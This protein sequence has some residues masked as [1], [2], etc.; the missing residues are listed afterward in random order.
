M[1]PFKKIGSFAV[2]LMAILTCFA[3]QKA[4]GQ[5]PNSSEQIDSFEKLY[6]ALSEGAILDLSDP[7]NRELFKLYLVENFVTKNGVMFLDDLISEL[8][9]NMDFKLMH[10]EGMDS[11]LL[12]AQQ[13]LWVRPLSIWEKP[14][15]GV[16]G[17]DCSTGSYP[18]K[19]LDPNFWVYTITNDRN[20]SNGHI[21]VVL[22]TAKGEK[23]KN[24]KIAMVDKIQSIPNEYI[25]DMLEMI[26]QSVALKGYQLGIPA[27]MGGTSD[28]LS[29]SD[30]IATFVS[31]EYDPYVNS[32]TKVKK[33]NAH[34]F[35]IESDKGYSRAYDS[36]DLV[37]LETP[38]N[39]KQFNTKKNA[40]NRA[41]ETSVVLNI[42][43]RISIVPE[44][45]TDRIDRVA[46]FSSYGL[47]S[48]LNMEMMD[49]DQWIKEFPTFPRQTQ[50]QL[51]QLFMSLNQQKA[52]DGKSYGLNTLYE[53]LVEAGDPKHVQDFIVLVQNIVQD[54]D[55]AFIAARYISEDMKKMVDQFIQNDESYKRNLK[56]IL[57]GYAK[58][59]A[60]ADFFSLMHMQYVRNSINR[61]E[62]V[63][64][65]KRATNEW[66]QLI[67]SK[68]G[69]ELIYMTDKGRV[70]I[71]ISAAA[72]RYTDKIA[73][74]HYPYDYV[75]DIHKNKFARIFYSE[76]FRNEIFD[77]KPIKNYL[78]YNFNEKHLDYI[79][80]AI[81]KYPDRIVRYLSKVSSGYDLSRSSLE[82]MRLRKRVPYL[83]LDIRMDSQIPFNEYVLHRWINLSGMDQFVKKILDRYEEGYFLGGGPDQKLQ[84]KM[85]VEEAVFLQKFSKLRS[86]YIIECLD[87]FLTPSEMG[88]G[89]VVVTSEYRKYI[90]VNAEAS[91]HMT[92]DALAIEKFVRDIE[93]NPVQQPVFD[94][95]RKG[96]GFDPKM[97]LHEQLKD[98][99]KLEFYQKS[100]LAHET[101]NPIEG[102]DEPG[103]V[104]EKKQAALRVLWR[105][106]LVNFRG[107]VSSD[108]ELKLI[109]NK[110][111]SAGVKIYGDPEYIRVTTDDYKQPYFQRFY[112]ATDIE[113]RASTAKEI[114]QDHIRINAFVSQ[115]RAQ[116]FGK[117]FFKDARA[118]KDQINSFLR[119]VFGY[120]SS[121]DT[122]DIEKFAES[123]VD[124]L[125][126]SA[127]PRDW[128]KRI[129]AL[130]GLI[131]ALQ[132]I[133]DTKPELKSALQIALA[134]Q[135]K[136]IEA[137]NEKIRRI[138]PLF[139]QEAPYAFNEDRLNSTAQKIAKENAEAG[140]A[141]SFERLEA[142][143]KITA[144]Q[145]RDIYLHH[146]NKLGASVVSAFEL[147][148][149]YE[150]KMFD[151]S[152]IKNFQ[153]L[154]DFYIQFFDDILGVDRAFINQT[155][156]SS[157]DWKLNDAQI[158]IFKSKP[159]MYQEYFSDGM[160]KYDPKQFLKVSSMMDLK[161][162]DT[163]LIHV[164]KRIEKFISE[165]MYM[166]VAEDATALD[167]V[168][169]LSDERD[170][171][172]VLK[173]YF[174]HP[175]VIQ[176][177]VILKK[178]MA[179][180]KAKKVPTVAE[181]TE[182]VTLGEYKKPARALIILEAVQNT[183][184]SLKKDLMISLL[185]I[186]SEYPLLK[187]KTI[188]EYFLKFHEAKVSITDKELKGIASI[189]A[190]SYF[191]DLEEHQKRAVRESIALIQERHP[192]IEK[193]TLDQV[194][195]SWF[196]AHL[197]GKTEEKGKELVAD[198]VKRKALVKS[199]DELTKLGI[200][201]DVSAEVTRKLA[202]STV[203]VL[204]IRGE[205][206]FKWTYELI[207]Q[208]MDALPEGKKIKTTHD[209]ITM[210]KDARK[211]AGLPDYYT[212][213]DVCE[214]EGKQLEDFGIEVNRME[215]RR[216]FSERFK[217]TYN[218]IANYVSG[219]QDVD[220]SRAMNAAKAQAEHDMATENEQVKGIPKPEAIVT[221]EAPPKVEDL[222]L[223][224]FAKEVGRWNK[225]NPTQIIDSKETYSYF[226]KQAISQ[227]IKLQEFD[228]L[229]VVCKKNGITPVRFF[230]LERIYRDQLLPKAKFETLVSWAKDEISLVEK[231]YTS[232]IAKSYM[233]NS[234]WMYLWFKERFQARQANQGNLSEVIEH[235]DMIRVYEK[236][237]ELKS[238]EKDNLMISRAA[239]IPTT[240][241]ESIRIQEE[242]SRRA[243]ET[244]AVTPENYQ[245]LFVNA[246]SWRNWKQ[247]E[248]VLDYVKINKIQ[249]SP[250][251][252][253]SPMGYVILTG[254]A[255]LTKQILEYAQKSGIILSKY[256]IEKFI[257]LA[258]DSYHANRN[259]NEVVIQ[260]LDL[261]FEY[262]Q[263][264]GI[265]IGQ[266]I[267]NE[268]VVMCGRN[269][270]WKMAEYMMGKGGEIEIGKNDRLKQTQ[271][272]RLN[273]IKAS[274][275]AEKVAAASL[276]PSTTAIPVT[277]YGHILR[278][279]PHSLNWGEVNRV[280]DDVIQNKTK[281]SVDDLS[282]SLRFIVLQGPT[283]TVRKIF[284]AVKVLDLKFSADQINRAF[285][286]LGYLNYPEV[287]EA[288][289][290][291]ENAKILLDYA[292]TAQ[293]TVE[294]ETIEATIRNAQET[295]KSDPRFV[296]FCSAQI[297]KTGGGQLFS[298]LPIK[299]GDG[300]KPPVFGKN[301][302]MSQ[303]LR[304]VRELATGTRP[305]P[306]RQPLYQVQ[307][308]NLT[309][310]EVIQWNENVSILNAESL[311]SQ[312]QGV[313]S[314]FGK[315]TIDK[316][317]KSQRTMI[318]NRDLSESEIK[319]ML[320]TAITLENF[321]VIR[322]KIGA[323]Y[324]VT[325]GVIHGSFT[326][327]LIGS[328]VKD[329]GEK[330]DPSMWR[331]FLG[332]RLLDRV[333]VNEFQVKFEELIAKINDQVQLEQK[334]E[335]LGKVKARKRIASI[336]KIESKK[337]QSIVE[338]MELFE[339]KNAFDYYRL[340]AI[341][342]TS[343]NLYSKSELE[344]FWKN[345]RLYYAK[346]AERL[347]GETK[348][349]VD[350]RVEIETAKRYSEMPVE[351][352]LSQM[353]VN[354]NLDVEDRTAVKQVYTVVPPPVRTTVVGTS[355]TQSSTGSTS[356]PPPAE[357][358]AK[359]AESAGWVDAT[360]RFFSGANYV[361]I[362]PAVEKMKSM[363]EMELIAALEKVPPSQVATEGARYV[364][365]VKELDARLKVLRMDGL[366]NKQSSYWKII[367][368][369]TEVSKKSMGKAG[370][371]HSQRT[372]IA[373]AGIKAMAE[374]GK[375]GIAL[376]VS[377]ALR[378]MTD[379][380]TDIEDMWTLVTHF[381]M[382]AVRL[383]TFTGSAGAGST[384]A[385]KM[386]DLVY[387]KAGPKLEAQAAQHLLEVNGGKK[388][389]SRSMLRKLVKGQIGFMV[390][391]MTNKLLWENGAQ[392]PDF[393]KNAFISF[394]SFGGAQVSY[395]MT[396]YGLRAIYSTAKV[397]TK[398]L[399]SMAI[400]AGPGG[401]FVAGV[402][403]G[404]EM[405]ISTHIESWMRGK[406][407]QT[408]FEKRIR[409]YS[410]MFS[411]EI[412]GSRGKNVPE[413]CKHYAKQTEES[414]SCIGNLLHQTINE[415]IQFEV[416][417]GLYELQADAIADQEVTLKHQ[418]VLTASLK[419]ES[420]IMDTVQKR[421]SA[422][423]YRAYK[424]GLVR[425]K[426]K[427]ENYLSAR[428]NE[429]EDVLED[430]NPSTLQVIANT[431]AILEKKSG[432]GKDCYAK[433]DMY[434][435]GQCIVLGNKTGNAYEAELS[436]LYYQ[437]AELNFDQ[438]WYRRLFSST[439]DGT[440]LGLE[441]R[442]KIAIGEVIEACRGR[443]RSLIA[444]T[445]AQ[446]EHVSNPEQLE[447]IQSAVKKYLMGQMKMMVEL[448]DEIK[449]SANGEDLKQFEKNIYRPVL[450]KVQVGENVLPASFMF[451]STSQEQAL[452]LT[453]HELKMIQSKTK[454][455]S[456]WLPKEVKNPSS[457]PLDEK[458][459]LALA[460]Y[461]VETTWKAMDSENFNGKYGRD[462]EQAEY[463]INN[464]RSGLD[465]GDVYIRKPDINVIREIK[466]KQHEEETTTQ[467]DSF[468]SAKA[469][470]IIDLSA[471]I[472]KG[473][474]IRQV[475]QNELDA[476]GKKLKKTNFDDLCYEVQFYRESFATD[477][478]QRITYDSQ[479]LIHQKPILYPQSIFYIGCDRDK[480]LRTQVLD[481]S[482][483][484]L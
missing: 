155:L 90:K 482:N 393:F 418:N 181:I 241:I 254:P 472:Q 3:P 443:G 473:N 92:Y 283:E 401:W 239:F 399:R 125:S 372:G 231:T 180:I 205:N 463:Q 177:S 404:I 183:N 152:K 101:G 455:I 193:A 428:S 21:T 311:L 150:T 9:K 222:S 61:L 331:D 30:K 377:E 346:K 405:F 332:N 278:N 247:F 425:V 251:S 295:G 483:N 440:I 433:Q 430:I 387:K 394:A 12:D 148:R 187:I 465:R 244:L 107:G 446:S 66:N 147:N 338:K 44:K 179:K 370:W 272:S 85:T 459:S 87:G 363:S 309:K 93:A 27:D 288:E 297:P 223:E 214:R 316:I 355:N 379:P 281:V 468:L 282:S 424:E 411:S 7:H 299:D 215:Q 476:S 302:L 298:T 146:K 58:E 400:E 466:Q 358:E 75:D 14:L 100:L 441:M 334:N 123:N 435:F 104:T 108:P 160:M 285:K 342:G 24:I 11:Y 471:E 34:P 5:G 157:K 310:Q 23:G 449:A 323:T 208:R 171:D 258:A 248:M 116:Y 192:E 218:A 226:L 133:Q 427:Y 307:A 429:Y 439:Y 330:L 207:K 366:K 62:N 233:R 165:K 164:K 236:A 406:E 240:P 176:K 293:I 89:N 324:W 308:L 20:E 220:G 49:I 130:E 221:T 48:Y 149:G 121:Q 131:R 412:V 95:L 102:I 410:A 326:K 70:E 348:G 43:D 63:S 163:L 396:K 174:K 291:I 260:H 1:A 276:P 52:A 56:T 238:L 212:A 79:D 145:I 117:P 436:E 484:T 98:P 475:S 8:R 395:K 47:L 464:E 261:I 209:W 255:S 373:G 301:S 434:E 445:R 362:L 420:Y 82:E 322:V 197:T 389:V 469:K 140:K 347:E 421:E 68:G 120:K 369:L 294:K 289:V 274:V 232:D 51:V 36:L 391:L 76:I 392:D 340:N 304:Y 65:R 167:Y 353:I 385:D 431:K 477:Q 15:R 129:D 402:E 33:F 296:E 416:F 452:E 227:G 275:E 315:D 132:P 319:E 243:T 194:K 22:G 175:E 60:A 201:K 359:K 234:Y 228:R 57:S 335:A 419:G 470:L 86:E 191:N 224:T 190:E 37:V 88:S 13:S 264:N 314:V 403:L 409:I 59:P 360:K 333:Q 458:T 206:Q 50:K 341:L 186:K 144:E 265:T 423:A 74:S 136:L 249:I 204:G 252:F 184:L 467:R 437:K 426:R 6:K 305:Q 268:T 73:N 42:A 329:M 279:A 321:D 111:T 357:P 286:T 292:K 371:D 277:D 262:A 351:K 91:K 407:V 115:H 376:L 35:S 2:L 71:D 55:V 432:L 156:Q 38:S 325:Q 4:L 80:A 368:R 17:N 320:R 270:Q 77:E 182:A 280:L 229:L 269:E 479:L 159:A 287:N 408:D 365:A 94:E 397:G 154:H 257:T 454:E 105:S 151:V 266:K 259:T 361:Y 72:K 40:L 135:K 96:I 16:I 26:R 67:K 185:S 343:G 124:P 271:I 39:P 336:L 303:G 109:F 318:R 417:K 422:Q 219:T 242:A 364:T 451:P 284:E 118:D 267:L 444:T 256:T 225:A 29:N 84:E 414:I 173:E 200:D 127:E 46:K 64:D 253:Y 25:S 337:V 114:I 112:D 210:D 461:L 263:K 10:Q 375:F 199:Q 447:G 380:K 478:A 18:L 456:V 213:R 19:S 83:K 106:I 99:K 119:N 367:D 53:S 480:A 45:I 300:S 78:L 178:V 390:G 344:F 158:E 327:M 237:E 312:A 128:K 388:F 352:A 103:V 126:S 143:P 450:A 166:E 457:G 413:L 306:L 378:V 211:A 202:D 384:F 189:Y 69:A 31:K 415:Y 188:E 345:A 138:E 113:V 217:L 474:Y 142:E 110:T 246:A 448:V 383:I 198:G 230:I 161:N 354:A 245:R 162:S 122:F 141:V 313:S 169:L 137:F 462:L 381:P 442:G 172:E 168:I 139:K 481:A 453:Q 356:N 374:G 97:P 216:P 438:S 54:P 460:T 81:K 235:K 195:Q 386:M 196:R 339:I 349:A 28:G 32:K 382:E 203:L 290:L 41:I 170:M 250:D 317:R 328:E 350:E 153:A 134:S 273:R 398:G